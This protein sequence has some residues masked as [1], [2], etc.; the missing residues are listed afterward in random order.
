MQNQIYKDKLYVN[1]IKKKERNIRSLF[2]NYE[3]TIILL[4]VDLL[5]IQLISDL[6]S[7]II[8]MTGS[9]FL[10]I[11]MKMYIQRILILFGLVVE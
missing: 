6:N 1:Y 8:V 7:A 11:S 2:E 5:L 4:F 9:A 3:N 10:W